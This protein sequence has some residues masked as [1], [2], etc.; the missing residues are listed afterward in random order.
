MAFRPTYLRGTT[1]LLEGDG[2][3]E[4]RAR[5]LADM[6]TLLR[7]ERAELSATGPTL[8]A[9]DHRVLRSFFDAY[10]DAMRAS[11]LPEAGA[12]E[13]ERREVLAAAML[14]SPELTRRVGERMGEAELGEEAAGD[15]PAPLPVASE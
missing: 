7:Q 4:N 5:A 6:M 1:L 3:P 10:A 9:S 12:R 2:S 14:V 11:P 15:A 8:T 13:R